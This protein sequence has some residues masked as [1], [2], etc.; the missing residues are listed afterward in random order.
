MEKN[1]KTVEEYVKEVKRLRG[2]LLIVCVL[3]LILFIPLMTLYLLNYHIGL[4]GLFGLFMLVLFSTIRVRKKVLQIR[5]ILTMECDPKKY[6]EIN[7]QLLN[8]PFYNKTGINNYQ[9]YFQALS[10]YYA[11]DLVEMKKNLEDIDFEAGTLDITL[12][13]YN[14]LGNY[15]KESNDL[16][17]LKA[18]IDAI[19]SLKSRKKF[20]RQIQQFYDSVDTIFYRHYLVLTNDKNA[21]TKLFDFLATEKE[22]LKKV[23][24]HFE[25][26]KLYLKTATFD[27]A[28]THFNY[29]LE[30]GG[31]TYYTVY[32]QKMIHQ[33]NEE[34][35]TNY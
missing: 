2:Y 21:L 15:Y 17:G 27:Q 16:E 9:K 30:H 18:T 10:D 20:P 23:G 28:T 6:V 32:A 31:E 25:I 35:W 19:R 24:L 13:Y 26:G 22:M 33:M 1:Q 34:E 11:G 14:L 8:K 4:L 29:V 3:G 7:L 5:T 12:Q